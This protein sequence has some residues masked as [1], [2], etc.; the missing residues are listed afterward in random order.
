MTWKMV[1]YFGFI[2]E[3]FREFYTTIFIKNYDYD[4]DRKIIVIIIIIAWFIW[5]ICRIVLINYM[6][7]IVSTK[8]YRFYIQIQNESTLIYIQ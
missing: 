7:E 6:C 3:F 5:Y 4:T 8:V 1:C 2:A